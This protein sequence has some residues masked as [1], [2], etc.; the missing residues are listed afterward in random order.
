MKGFATS[1]FWTV[2][3]VIVALVALLIIMLMMI[4]T[5]FPFCPFGPAQAV[6]AINYV[7]AYNTPYTI[8][9]VLSQYNLGDAKGNEKTLIDYAY[10]TLLTGDMNVA[11]KEYLAAK[12]KDVL[13]KYKLSYYEVFVTSSDGPLLQFGKTLQK[14]GPK[15]EGTCTVTTGGAVDGIR[16]GTCDVGRTEI[17]AIENGC[18]FGILCCTTVSQDKYYKWLDEHPGSVPAAEQKMAVVKCGADEA[19]ICTRSECDFGEISIAG[20]CKYVNDGK[21]PNCCSTNPDVLKNAGKIADAEI[22]LFYGGK[23]GTLVVR[24]SD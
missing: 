17:N 11:D 24:T 21:T 23:D 5:L 2:V 12:L 18:G 7:D 13:D 10:E 9:S 15:L 14:C 16:V 6:Y 22:P 1:Y 4:C 19:G 3:V 8:A 20:N